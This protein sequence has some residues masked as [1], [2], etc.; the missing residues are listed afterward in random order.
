MPCARAMR[1]TTR[2][3]RPRSTCRSS[4]LCTRTASSRI[5]SVTVLPSFSPAVAASVRSAAA[6]RPCGRSPCPMSPRR[7]VQL[8][9]RRAACAATRRRA[10]RRADRPAPSPAL[11][12]RRARRSRRVAGAH[13]RLG[14]RGR[15]GRGDRRQMTRDQ[16]A[17]RI[18]R[19]RA[20]ARSSSRRAPSRRRRAPAW[21]ADCSVRGFRRSELSRAARE[22]V[23]TTRKNGRFLE[24]ARRKRIAT[25]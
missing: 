16:R 10:R 19:L 24:P 5:S 9:E 1:P 11:R 22:S 12:R 8:D 13:L 2:H 4:G 7:D 18:R 3:R 21:C 25:I 23:T 15:G 6:V 20:L 17:H 14:R